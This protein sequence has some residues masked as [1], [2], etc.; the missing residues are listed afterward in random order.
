[1]YG[2]KPDSV[3]VS[4]QTTTEAGKQAKNRKRNANRDSLD[5]VPEMKRTKTEPDE[6]EVAIQGEEK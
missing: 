3:T 1:M 5:L 2:R 4:Y 6:K